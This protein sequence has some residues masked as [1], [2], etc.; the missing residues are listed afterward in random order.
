MS[1]TII[2]RL[3]SFA[4]FGRV[5]VNKNSTLLDLKKEVCNILTLFSFIFIDF[6]NYKCKHK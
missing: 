4:G 1:Q 3:I 5:E 6:K 2:F